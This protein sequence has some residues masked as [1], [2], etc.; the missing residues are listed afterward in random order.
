MN[1]PAPFKIKFHL[2]T[3]IHVIQICAIMAA[4][5]VLPH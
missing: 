4:K 1:F 3:V 2:G 5:L